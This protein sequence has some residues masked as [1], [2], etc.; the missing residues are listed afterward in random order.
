MVDKFSKIAHFI[1]CHKN[2]YVKLIAD[3]FFKEL[4]IL[5]GIPKSIVS[6]KDVKFLSHLWHVLW[7]EGRK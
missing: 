3:L 4:V 7:G 2:D 6:D 5:H 1:Q